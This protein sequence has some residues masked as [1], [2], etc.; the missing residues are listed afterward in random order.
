[1]IKKEETLLD[2]VTSTAT[3]ETVGVLRVQNKTIVFTG[4]TTPVGTVVLEASAITESDWVLLA[5]KT[6]PSTPVAIYVNNTYKFMRARM[7][8]YTSGAF[9][10]ELV[11]ASND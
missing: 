1:M 11:G 10:V 5:T 9:T 6:N 2:G 8:A 3:G 7:T 4:T